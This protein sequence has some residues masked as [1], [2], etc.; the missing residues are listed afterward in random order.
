M[1]LDPS[2][3]GNVRALFLLFGK[4]MGLSLSR[5]RDRG[6]RNVQGISRSH[7]QLVLRHRLEGKARRRHRERIEFCPSGAAIG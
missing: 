3:S 1:A 7:G 6:N 4:A 5:A 2:T